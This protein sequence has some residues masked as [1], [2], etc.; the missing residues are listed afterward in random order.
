MLE[1]LAVDGM[2]G[3]VAIREC[4]NILESLANVSI[5]EKT[6]VK[7]S[8]S[9]IHGSRSYSSLSENAADRRD[10]Q[11]ERIRDLVW[12][13][14]AFECEGTFTLQYTETEEDG[15]LKSYIQPRMIF[16]N[17]DM[18]I[19]QK[20]ERI[21]V[22]NDFVKPYRR[23]GIQSGIGKKKKTEI[24]CLGKKALPILRLLRPYI[25]GDKAECVDMMIEFIVY[26]QSLKQINQPYTDYE[27]GLFNR[28]RAIN[29][30]HWKRKPK[31]S[32]LSSETVRQRRLDA[33][34]RADAAMIQ[35]AL[36]G[37]AQNAKE[38]IASM[39]SRR[40]SQRKRQYPDYV[41]E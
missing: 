36:R 26:R 4:A 9:Q 10:Y 11:Q 20:V 1:T 6:V 24:A 37:D 21:L 15:G 22:D 16:V 25:V 7:G 13:A 39:M 28:V 14:C 30:G 3:S 8:L 18:K 19:A 27:Y 17:S 38:T 5:E 34:K 23:N 40:I 31:F 33:W 41:H 32:E 35:S 29:S 12:L 2:I